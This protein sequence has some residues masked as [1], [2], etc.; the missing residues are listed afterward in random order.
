V[1]ARVGVGLGFSLLIGAAGQRLGALS[2]SG[3]LASVAIG[4]CVV[5]GASR[6]GAVNLAAF[7]AP[8][9]A[10]SRI[11]RP[12]AFGGKGGRRDAAQVLA[13]GAV[14]AAAALAAPW[15]GRSRA[16]AVLAGAL[17]A[18]AADTWA[19]EIGSRSR[20]VPRLLTTWKP[21]QRGVS[22]AVT[23][24]GLA[25]SIA[26]ALSVGCADRWAARPPMGGR[27]TCLSITAAGVVGALADSALGA[28]LQ[29]RR[30]CATCAAP[31]EAT[32]HVCGSTTSVAGGVPGVTN[33]VVN[34][35]CTLVGGMAAG[36]LT[37]D[38]DDVWH[39]RRS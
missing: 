35:L 36:L 18:A 34:L 26:G 4:T 21:T 22:G 1:I 7:F 38:S 23:P 5:A 2:R 39:T 29:E 13:N 19:T 30:W 6:R 8:S 3:A 15:L 24:L 20:A 27:R 10:L 33:D 28:T 16:H 31:T 17:A 25:A 14:A 11:A 9:S 12:H 32:R 37:R